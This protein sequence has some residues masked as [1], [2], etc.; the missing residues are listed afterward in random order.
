MFSAP[1]VSPAGRRDI[2]KTSFLKEKARISTTGRAIAA[3]PASISPPVKTPA[4]LFL[5]VCLVY[6]KHYKPF[7]SA[8]K[9]EVNTQQLT[10]F[11]RFSAEPLTR[12]VCVC[13]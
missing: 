11:N 4:D 3:S 7:S 8:Q 2:S 9:L 13:E 5:C 12:S 6:L 1:L 10:A